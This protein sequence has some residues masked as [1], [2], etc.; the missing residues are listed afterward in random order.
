MLIVFVMVAVRRGCTSAGM[1][2]SPTDP[3]VETCRAQ[4]DVDLD[5]RD[6]RETFGWEKEETKA[7]YPDEIAV[8]ADLQRK[9]FAAEDTAMVVIVQAMDAGA[10]RARSAPC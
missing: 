7:A 4:P 3:I 10:R 5:H 6:S 8:V 9:F 2:I 1:S